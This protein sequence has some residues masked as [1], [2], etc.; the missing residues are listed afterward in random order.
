MLPET[1]G[2]AVSGK[3]YFRVEKESYMGI[4]VFNLSRR[5][6]STPIWEKSL[7]GKIYSKLFFPPHWEEDGVAK[8]NEAAKLGAFAVCK[9]L[10][11]TYGLIPDRIVSS[12]E[13]GVYISY[14]EKRNEVEK[15]LAVEVYN[16][17]EVAAL[18]NLDSERRILY[19]EDIRDMRF[20]KVMKVF[21]D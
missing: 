8:P 20:E 5:L 2:L 19:S 21:R 10:L 16:T 11:G 12:I 6:S 3:E 17:S 15:T 18:V 9:S 7:E 4:E 14:T 13:G 1:D